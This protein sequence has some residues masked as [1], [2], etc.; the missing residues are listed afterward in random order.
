MNDEAPGCIGA[1]E[2]PHS[3]LPWTNECSHGQ[4]EKDLLSPAALPV[5]LQQRKGVPHLRVEGKG[6]KVRYLPLHVLAQQLITAYLKA[7][8]HAA[9]LHGPL[10]RPV[11]NNRTRANLAN[12]SGRLFG[13]KG[14]ASSMTPRIGG[15]SRPH[16]GAARGQTPARW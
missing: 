15:N 4:T 1:A 11:K 14:T 8:V 12:I 2:P 3:V 5:D 9:D 7:S 16:S 13:R 10:F 6:D